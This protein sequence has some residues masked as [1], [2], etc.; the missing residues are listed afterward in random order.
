MKKILLHIISKGNCT[1][2]LGDSC[3]YCL[4]NLF[5]GTK[6]SLHPN[7]KLIALKLYRELYGEDGDLF[8]ELL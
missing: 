5:S 8:E 4:L 7:K 3:S 6:E 1:G 2:L